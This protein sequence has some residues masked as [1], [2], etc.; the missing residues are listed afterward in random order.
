MNEGTNQRHEHEL[1]RNDT[2]MRGNER[3]GKKR[4]DNYKWMDGWMDGWMDDWMI[5]PLKDWMIGW[6]DDW[7]VE[8]WNEWK[9]YAKEWQNG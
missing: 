4:K 5:E 9:Q 1:K 8:W 2:K 7:M 3:K 6:L